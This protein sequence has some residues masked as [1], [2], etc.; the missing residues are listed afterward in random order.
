MTVHITDNLSQTSDEWHKRGV[1]LPQFDPDE[2][3]A[4]SADHPYWLHFGAG[5]LF[6]AVHAPLAQSLL[7]QGVVRS[8][9]FVAETFDP[10]IVSAVYTP[11]KDRSLAVVLKADGSMD[12][13]LVASVAGAFG[14]ASHDETWSRLVKVFTNP[15]LQ[16]ITVTVTEKGYALRNAQGELLPWISGEV[17]HGPDAAV[18]AMGAIT[19]LLYERFKAGKRPLALVSTD[20]FSQNGDRFGSTIREFAGLWKDRGFVPQEFVDYLN[21][22][23]KIAFPLTMIDRITPNPAQSVS[24]QLAERGF[25]DTAIVHT[26]KGT[27]VAPFTNTEETWYLVIEDDFPNGRPDLSKAGIYL[28]DRDTVN[29]A[30]EMKVTTCLNPVHTALA[31]FGRLLGIDVMFR[32]VTDPDLHALVERLGY[33][34]DLPVAPNPGIISP[35]DFLRKVIDVRVPNPNMPDT[36]VRISTDTS[37]KI[38]IRYGV[39]LRKYV[40]APDRDPN[41]L[42]AIP[43]VI[44]GW[45]R[46]LLGADGKATD[47]NGQQ[48]MLSPD[49][50][51]PQLQQALAPL[52]LGGDLS[53]AANVLKPILADSTLFGV[54][55]TK[56]PLAAR[57]TDY[58]TQFA[59]GTHTVRPVL[60][61]ALGR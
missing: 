49:P 6:R 61:K 37:Q 20:N 9:I 18:S 14:I 35:R 13:E 10:E 31:T 1:K 32:T 11:N 57:I 36:P 45:L 26:A 17:E 54:D 29:K 12:L 34:E 46:L 28:A 47:D 50:R 5:N 30:D 8:G 55:L 7:N 22:P 52:K 3:R 43:L 48:I 27:N 23:K 19:A 40:T 15:E 16:F 4:H 44:A 25:A 2:V 21:D 41:T 51:I 42:I 58:F 39:T 53:S 56:T 59:T 24:K 33:D 60:R 38:P